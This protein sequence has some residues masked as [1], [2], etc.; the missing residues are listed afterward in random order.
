MELYTSIP[1]TVGA[2]VMAV[3]RASRGDEVRLAALMGQVYVQ[4]GIRAW[5]F[6]DKD[7][8]PIQVDPSSR[9]WP[10]TVAELLPW[11]EGGAL[12]ADRAD[13]L[14]SENVLRPLTG[15][16]LTQSLDG[17]TA[18]SISPIQPSQPKRQRRSRPSS[19]TSTDGRPSEAQAP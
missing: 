9:D 2:G 13:E 11:D 12:V 5:S 15:R 8:S 17:Q 1:I 3:M 19:P 6:V 7:G 14:Y 10:D 18:G 4:N 16:T